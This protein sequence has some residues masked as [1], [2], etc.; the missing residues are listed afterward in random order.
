[1]YFLHANLVNL[2]TWCGI[3]L[4]CHVKVMSASKLDFDTGKSRIK[5]LPKIVKKTQ[6]NNTVGGNANL[7]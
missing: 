1:M 7:K 5:Q 2:L 6:K 4:C 3:T